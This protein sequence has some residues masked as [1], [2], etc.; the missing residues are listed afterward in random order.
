M[1]LVFF[2]QNKAL[3]NEFQSSHQNAIDAFPHGP[4]LP[5]R[6]NVTEMEKKSSS[7][8]GMTCQTEKKPTNVTLYDSSD[9]NLSTAGPQWTS[10][11]AAWW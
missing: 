7:V 5:A 8:S 2:H 10:T 9:W 6:L 1:C 11:G 4:L 3:G